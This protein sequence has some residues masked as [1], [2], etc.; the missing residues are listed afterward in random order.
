M[1]D[2]TRLAG[3]FWLPEDAEQHP[4]PAILEDMP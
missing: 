2:G 1:S 4:V 3:R